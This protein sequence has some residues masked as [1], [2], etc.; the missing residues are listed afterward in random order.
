MFWS[1]SSHFGQVFNLHSQ[2]PAPAH[3]LLDRLKTTSFFFSFLHLRYYT[4]SSSPTSIP[5]GGVFYVTKATAMAIHR[6]SSLRKVRYLPASRNVLFF[7]PLFS[8]FCI[9][10]LFHA[11]L[12]L[13]FYLSRVLHSLAG[14][15]LV[16]FI[17]S[18][19]FIY[20]WRVSGGKG[21]RSERRWSWRV[22]EQS[23]GLCSP[24]CTFFFSMEISGEGSL[25]SRYA[26]KG[27]GS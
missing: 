7:V 2:E 22:R 8:F 12:S 14:V 26:T 11:S 17:F 10:F 16:G 21:R 27:E 4:T 25:I 15:L 5:W 9:F 3:S 24:A 20:P 18:F 1:I 23:G 19:A 6:G 13:L